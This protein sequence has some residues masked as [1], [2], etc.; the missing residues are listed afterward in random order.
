MS[1]IEL[2]P[3]QITDNPFQMIGKD[4]MLI[5]AGDP[6]K[7]NTMTAAWGG[8]GVLWNRPV[9][10]IFVR[11]Q[12]YTWQFTERHHHY[13][14]CFLD[15]ARYRKEMI[16]LGTASGRDEDKIAKAGLTLRWQDGVPYFEEAKLV[17][18]CKKLYRDDLEEGCFTDPEALNDSYPLR[19]FHR[20]YVGQV[21][22]ALQQE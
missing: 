7:C 3:E 10:F 13:S 12:R 11:P 6:D 4:W 9:S 19:D 2:N 17:L 14:L 22:K 16:Y 5:T 15:P 8:L 20:M 1:F 18:I 21:I